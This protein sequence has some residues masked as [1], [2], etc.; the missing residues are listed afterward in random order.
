MTEREQA[1]A[2]GWYAIWTRSRHEQVVREQLERKQIEAFLPTVT[3]WSRWKDRKKRIDWPVPFASRHRIDA[4]PPASGPK[5]KQAF[6]EKPPICQNNWKKSRR[7][8]RKCCNSRISG[9]G[10]YE[11]WKSISA[12]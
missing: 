8:W 10:W 1:P 5:K 7:T 2:A 3:R 9:I 4:G 11:A 12:D 6:A